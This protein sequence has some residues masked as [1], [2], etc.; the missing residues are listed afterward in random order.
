MKLNDL[1]EGI[2]D[3]L[4][5]A[6]RATAGLL[7]RGLGA[8]AG[9][10]GQTAGTLGTAF[11]RA[12]G[13]D[14][15]QG[16]V[17]TVQKSIAKQKFVGTFMQKMIGFISSTSEA[18]KDD[19]LKIQQQQAQQQAAQQAQQQGQPIPPPGQIIVPQTY[20]ARPKE[21]IDFER[22]YT[23]IINEDQATDQLIQQYAST[24]EKGIQSYMSG[25]LGNLVGQVKSVSQTIAQKI[26][27]GE[28][29]SPDLENLGSAIFDQYYSSER[30]KFT[31][32]H[33]AADIPL[34]SDGE[35][36]LA[37]LRNLSNKEQQVVMQ[38]LEKGGNLF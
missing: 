4:K 24:I 23:R 27:N 8:V 38:K 13:F 18:V 11:A 7:G 15:S 20:R 30:S 25:N 26:A 32:T 29:Y 10:A 33:S 9:S 36:V 34:S 6:G 16:E 2:G 35:Q 37:A 21:S 3:S 22:L 1:D 12:I 19:L 14:A 31:Q 5:T 28:N 17:G